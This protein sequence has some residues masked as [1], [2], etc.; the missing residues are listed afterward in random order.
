KDSVWKE[1]G[2]TVAEQIAG[3]EGPLW[4]TSQLRASNECPSRPGILLNRHCNTVKWPP[5]R[6]AEEAQ[7]KIRR[8][9][10]ILGHLTGPGRT[11]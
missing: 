3:K 9:S 1:L 2:Q 4:L 6:S 11:F 10:E 8:H 7:R 5:Y